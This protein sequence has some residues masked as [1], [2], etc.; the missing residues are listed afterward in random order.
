MELFLSEGLFA[1]YQFS[2]LYKIKLATLVEG[3]LKVPF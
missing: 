1:Y 2:L 3:D